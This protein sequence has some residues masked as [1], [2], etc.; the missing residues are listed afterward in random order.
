MADLEAPEPTFADLAEA[1]LQCRECDGLKLST[2]RDRRNCVEHELLPRL[3]TVPPAEISPE[4]LYDVRLALSEH[5]SPNRTYRVL[6][7]L[8]AIL[9]QAWR[10]GLISTNP[11]AALL[12]RKP[13]RVRPPRR[14]P[15]WD[16]VRKLIAAADRMTNE[17]APTPAPFATQLKMAVET[18]IRPS[19]RR[20]LIWL[21]VDLEQCELSIPDPRR[22]RT[23]RR[24]PITATLSRELAKLARSRPYSPENLVFPSRRGQMTSRGTLGRALAKLQMKEG[25]LA[26]AT[27]RGGQGKWSPRY[28]L[29][30]LRLVAPTWW[31]S[32]GVSS[33]QV[34]RLMGWSPQWDDFSECRHLMGEESISPAIT[35]ALERQLYG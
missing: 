16:D 2:L 19:E 6:L 31:R 34:R 8:K 10:D 13:Q 11:G 4:V 18:G 29:G 27:G 17:A 32:M 35:V 7:H 23:S 24:V 33:A 12:L 3:G 22:L 14:P 1:W 30:D 26:N 20:S 9:N 21:S 25:L 28:Q 15:P 5:G